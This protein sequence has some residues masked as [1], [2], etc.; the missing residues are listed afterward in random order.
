MVLLLQWGRVPKDWELA[1]VLKMEAAQSQGIDFRAI[2]KADLPAVLGEVP[3]GVLLRWVGKKAKANPKTFVKTV[4]K[5]FGRSGRQIIVGLQEIQDQGRMVVAEKSLEEEF[6]PLIDA[7]N[8][9]DAAKVVL[10]E[11]KSN[12]SHE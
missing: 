5:I 10:A 7:I 4:N 3:S 2:L 6:Q 8:Q 12:H 11:A 1:F 9:A